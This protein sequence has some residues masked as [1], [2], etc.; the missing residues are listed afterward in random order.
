MIYHIY[1]TRDLLLHKLYVCVGR[2]TGGTRATAVPDGAAGAGSFW[3]PGS[4]SH[5]A[6]GAL[7]IGATVAVAGPAAGQKIPDRHPD[8]VRAEVRP[9]TFEER[10]EPVRGLLA[11]QAFGV[12]VSEPPP[13]QNAPAAPAVDPVPV[14]R[15]RTV[16]VTIR[17]PDQETCRRHGRRTVWSGQS[18][19]CRR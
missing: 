6:I 7:A 14:P 1:E 12:L 18:W 10:W 11:R 16:M 3:R 4:R 13:K 19:R 8:M 9:L 5:R 15:V 17:K 2:L